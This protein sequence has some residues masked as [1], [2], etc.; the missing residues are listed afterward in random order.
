MS[1]KRSRF[2]LGNTLLYFDKSECNPS[3]RAVQPW[4]S[5]S[6]HALCPDHKNLAALVICNDF[7]DNDGSL[8]ALTH[9]LCNTV[10]QQVPL[11]NI[12]PLVHMSFYNI[13][14]LPSCSHNNLYIY[15]YLHLQPCSFVPTANFL[16]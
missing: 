13:Q 7:L 6:Q 4:N 1:D 10:K 5:V 3:S 12:C 2:N 16:F 14:S 15:L 8:S 11:T 9:F